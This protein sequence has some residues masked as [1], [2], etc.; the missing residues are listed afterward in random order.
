MY[1]VE[2][3]IRTWATMEG[4]GA[5]VLTTALSQPSLKRGSTDNCLSLGAN[6]LINMKIIPFVFY[7][8]YMFY[9]NPWEKINS[10]TSRSVLH[11][12]VHTISLI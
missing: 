3:E 5:S 9:N 8:M 12:H 6:T 10:P 4:R 2:S 11:V 1:D 7:T